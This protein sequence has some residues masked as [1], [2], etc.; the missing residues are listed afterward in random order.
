MSDEVAG[1]I[2]KTKNAAKRRT[3]YFFVCLKAGELARPKN[4]PFMNI[5]MN[6]PLTLYDIFNF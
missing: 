2:G 4:R 1:F 5:F 3:R 6:F